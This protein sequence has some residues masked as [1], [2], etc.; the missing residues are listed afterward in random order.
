VY[1][2]LTTS[3]SW[4]WRIRQAGPED[5][6][7]LAAFGGRLFQEAFAKDN[8]PEDMARYLAENFATPILLRELQEPGAQMLLLEQE[9]E[10]VGWAHLRPSSPGG[11][12]QHPF[13]IRRFY[14]DARWHGTGAAAALL[15]AVLQQARAVGADA[16]WLGVWEHNRR[17]QA[18]YAKHGFAPVGRQPFQLGTDLQTDDVLLRPASFGLTLAIVAGGSAR[19]LGGIA[20]PLLRV[21]GRSI[22]DRLLDLSPLADEVLLVSSDARFD[23]WGLRRIEDVL[24]DHGAPGGVHAALSEATQPWVLAVAGDMPFAD[25]LAVLPLLAARSEDVDAVAYTVGRRLEPL[26]ALYRRSLARPWAAALGTGAP[27]FR[28]LWETLR[29]R[30]L[31]EDVLHHATGALRAVT[32]LNTPE[33]IARWVQGPPTS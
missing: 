3:R 17:A 30:Q 16:V 33:D 21:E 27:S 12:G 9:G 31:G 25:G 6:P 7:F 4:P 2:L 8:R 10:R 5:A 13:E 14:I 29:G 28:D 15:S 24:P 23:G 20:K 19:R 11:R 22:L 1:R 26:L 18:F 32:S